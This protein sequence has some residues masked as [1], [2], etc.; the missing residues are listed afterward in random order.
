MDI[1]SLQQ[2][3]KDF[4]IYKNYLY[5]Y[6]DYLYKN[7]RF[8]KAKSIYE[9]LYSF[10]DIKANKQ[11]NNLLDIYKRDKELKKY[12]KLKFFKEI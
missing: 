3:D 9:E 2:D 7:E 6:A 4:K 5:D 10:K 11:F 1:N 8:D 12:F